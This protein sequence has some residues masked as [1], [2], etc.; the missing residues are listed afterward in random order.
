MSSSGHGRRLDYDAYVTE[1]IQMFD[2]PRHGAKQWAV[3]PAAK[4]LRYRLTKGDSDQAINSENYSI[5]EIVEKARAF[6]FDERFAVS[7]PRPTDL[8]EFWVG[9]YPSNMEERYELWKIVFIN[10]EC[11]D[12]IQI[13]GPAATGLWWGGALSPV[14]RLVLGFDHTLRQALW[15]MG[16]IDPAAPDPCAAFAAFCPPS[17]RVQA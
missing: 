8:F 7:T 11:L 13:C 1:Q 10:G 9:G 4:E 3:R 15:A 17:D 5:K 16:G 14:S 2:S 6:L 12:P